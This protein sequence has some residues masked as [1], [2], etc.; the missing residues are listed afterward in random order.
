MIRTAI[1]TRVS[2]QMQ[3]EE[4]FSLPAQLERLRAYCAS[5][6]WDVT[7]IYTDEGESA[8]STD[9]PELQRML[10][11]IKEKKIDIVLVYRL[12]RLTRSVLD[13]Y[14][15]LKIFDMHNVGFKSSTEV[16]DTTTAMG[17]LFITIV[18]ALAQW[19]R[20][21][22]GER[23][24]FG[25]RQKAKT[26]QLVTPRELFGYNLANG[27]LVINENEAEIVREIFRLYLSGNGMIR[28]LKWLN[29]PDYP[30]LGR[31]MSHWSHHSLNYLI[32]NPFYAGYIRYDK[33]AKEAII[34]KADH[35]PIIN[36]E[37]F[38]RAQEIKKE[39]RNKGRGGTGRFP[40]V[41][42]LRCH[43]GATMIGSQS[44]V[45]GKLYRYYQCA[46]AY[47]N[48]C[49]WKYRRADEIEKE[50]IQK[51]AELV[52]D[53][54]NAEPKRKKLEPKKD[55]IYLLRNV[56]EKKKRLWDAYEAGLTPLDELKR[57]LE[58]LNEEEKAIKHT[59]TELSEEE[60]KKSIVNSLNHLRAFWDKAEALEQKEAARAVIERIDIQEDGFLVIHLKN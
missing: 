41:G 26:G 39:R 14:E 23:V 30:Q 3:V 48:K 59:P 9:R 10:T 24:K 22:L 20:E 8:K 21:N 31:K 2:S 60:R 28:I 12:D 4:G 7:D 25:S 53:L 17:R 56:A 37:I 16:F 54:S 49:N 32:S 29:D 11:D 18:A 46:N 47:I 6:D 15:L 19:E 35:E 52:R 57:R 1:Y 36:E 13:L 33:S 27:K 44:T 34:E 43:C 38:E 55:I 40:L 5:Q 42:L 45:N 50:F 58:R 51:I